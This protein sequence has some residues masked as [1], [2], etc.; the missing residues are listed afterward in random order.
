MMDLVPRIYF[1][2]SLCPSVHS[3]MLWASLLHQFQKVLQSCFL[4]NF[5]HFNKILKVEIKGIESKSILIAM[6]ENS[7]VPSWQKDSYVNTSFFTKGFNYI[8]E[9]ILTIRCLHLEKKFSC[10]ILWFLRLT[11]CLSNFPF[12]C[13]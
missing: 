13:M 9:Y 5:I 12:W 1:L 11:W 10:N 4:V 6:L 2:R 3:E 7:L 8:S